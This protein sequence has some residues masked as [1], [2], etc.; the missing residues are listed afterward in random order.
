MLIGLDKIGLDVGVALTITSGHSFFLA[1]I[2]LK[3]LENGE[4]S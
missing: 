1:Y 2:C 4:I 3:S